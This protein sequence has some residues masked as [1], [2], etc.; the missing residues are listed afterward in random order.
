MLVFWATVKKFVSANVPPSKSRLCKRSTVKKSVSANVLPSKS[1]LC[2]RSTVK[3]SSLQTFYRQKVV[4][5][6]VLS[7]TTYSLHNNNKCLGNWAKFKEATLLKS[8]KL[9]WILPQQN[10]FSEKYDRISRADDDISVSK[11]LVLFLFSGFFTALCE[12][13]LHWIL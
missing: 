3:M 6:N 1:C 4:P 8:T 13:L 2:K 10:H 12:K 9:Y 11:Y 7:V 5:A